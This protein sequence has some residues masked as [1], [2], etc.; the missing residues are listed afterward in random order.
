MS[1]RI[2][3][4]VSGNEYSAELNNSITAN[5]IVEAL[6]FQ[7]TAMLWGEE[8]YFAVPVN[9]DFETDAHEIVEVGELAFYPP[10]NA[11]CI[12]FGPTP[13]STDSKPRGAD[14]VNVFGKIIG[15]TEKLKDVNNGD[16]VVVEAVSD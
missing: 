16:M 4:K 1:K 14:R 9:T 12:F 11:F 13:A 10:M 15:E 8:I 2:K 6:P 7:G 5:K 3:I